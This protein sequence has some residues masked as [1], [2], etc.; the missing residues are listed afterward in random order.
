MRQLL[1]HGAAAL[2]VVAIGHLLGQRRAGRP[3][4]W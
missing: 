3:T 4:R 1:V 2:V